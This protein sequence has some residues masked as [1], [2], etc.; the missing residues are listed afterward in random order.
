MYPKYIS[1]SRR[2]ACRNS[3]VRS[4]RKFLNPLKN[5]ALIFSNSTFSSAVSWVSD[6]SRLEPLSDKILHQSVGSPI[7]QHPLHLPGQVFSQ[8]ARGRKPEQLLI[9]H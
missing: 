5:S 4:A 1:V 6:F 3:P 7:R 9:R 8:L 2:I